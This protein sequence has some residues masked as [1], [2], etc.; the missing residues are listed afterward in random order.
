MKEL[1]LTAPRTLTYREYEERAIKPGEVRAV[2]VAGS[3]SHG[4]ELNEYRGK[5]PFA[6]KRFDSRLRLFVPADTSLSFPRPLGYEW[7]GRVVEVGSES[8]GYKPG[9]LVHLPLPHRESQIFPTGGIGPGAWDLKLPEGIQ[10]ERAAMLQSTTI[11]LQAVQ[12]ARI[13]LGDRVA[14]FGL[15][16]LGLIACQL[17]KRSGAGWVVGIDPIAVRRNAAAAF[18]V[19]LT[20]DPSACDPGQEIRGGD[21]LD[22][23]DVAI[24]ISGSYA[25]LHQ[26]I[27]SVRQGGLV[28]AAG[29]YQGGAEALRLG[30]EWSH[31]RV[32]MVASM[33]GWGNAH[34]DYPR[35][36]RNR[37]RATAAG[38]LHQGGL[39]VDLLITHRI[40]FEDAVGAYRL[41][42][43][44]AQDML[45][46]LLVYRP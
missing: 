36:D 5:S 19:D 22:A 46:V 28:V 16:A 39:S 6:E 14:V 4:T 40:P 8:V 11:V 42:D 23:A 33:Q 41:L 9:D 38:L 44:G 27:R 24:E 37:L 12:D 43:S 29:Y 13:R 7:V 34:R 32:S 20:L 18:G 35:W 15:G 31:N 26:A 1:L 45:K 30:E 10:P 17:V 21:A 3:L 2:A 25:A